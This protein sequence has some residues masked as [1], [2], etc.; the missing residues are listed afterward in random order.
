M[1]GRASHVDR[2]S[3]C[4]VTELVTSHVLYHSLAQRVKLCKISAISS[5]TK[6]TLKNKKKKRRLGKDLGQRALKANISAEKQ[7]LT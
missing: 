1:I 3:Y 6:Q 5:I 2:P 7:T 4:P